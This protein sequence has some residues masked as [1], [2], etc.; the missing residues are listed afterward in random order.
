MRSVDGVAGLEITIVFQ[1]LNI[2]IEL[3]QSGRQGTGDEHRVAIVGPARFT[4][5]GYKLPGR[6]GVWRHRYGIH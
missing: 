3:G 5:P 4:A 6:L 2:V 1:P